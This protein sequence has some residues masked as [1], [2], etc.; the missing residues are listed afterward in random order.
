MKR[1]A[2]YSK[3][4]FIFILSLCSL[5]TFSQDITGIWKGYFISDD[6]Q[7]YRL[8]FQ[9]KQNAKGEIAVSGVSYSWQ[10]DIKFYGKATM[11]GSFIRTSKN[12]KIKEIKTVEVK[13]ATGFGT[14]IMNYNLVYSRSGKEEFLEGSYLGKPEVKGRQNTYSW[15]DCGGGTVSLR[16]VTTSDFYVEPFLRRRNNPVTTPA[17][18][19]ALSKKTPPVAIKKAPVVVKQNPTK[20][21]TTKPVVKNNTKINPPLTQKTDTTKITRINTPVIK[22][23]LKPVINVPAVLKERSNEL[24][25]SLVV[26]EQDVTV[27]LYDNGEIDDDTI[28]IYYDKRL[29]ISGKRLSTT[30][31]VV[32]LRI[33]DENEVH[34]LVMVAENLGRIP[35]NT[36]LMIVDAGDQRFDV[37][38]TSTE[39][40]NALV[41]FSYQRPK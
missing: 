19:S 14:C 27:K 38:I 41:R 10:D 18:D 25:K 29:L 30:P 24:M 40:K 31:I 22:T 36:A 33:D 7:H 37:R 21:P 5:L 23:P 4:L 20:K 9:V 28:S 8:E 3:P 11:T 17:K 39:Q 1:I 12:F 13:S 34:E 26:N 16:R 35:P 15:G 32:K 6:G 2:L